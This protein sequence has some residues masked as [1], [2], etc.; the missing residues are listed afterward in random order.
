M[1]RLGVVTQWRVFSHKLQMALPVSWERRGEEK[2]A[3]SC[4]RFIILP[5]RCS[6]L[7]GLFSHGLEIPEC[8]VPV[9][10]VVPTAPSPLQHCMRGRS[11]GCNANTERSSC[12]DYPTADPWYLLSAC[13][14]IGSTQPALA[15]KCKY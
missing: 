10:Q 7:T 14:V 11:K 9:R 1:A 5:A 15:S 8:L 6:V 3:W 2:L 13:A 4:W 12:S